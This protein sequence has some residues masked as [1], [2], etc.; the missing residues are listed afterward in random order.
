MS[1]RLVN[2]FEVPASTP[3]NAP[4]ATGGDVKSLISWFVMRLVKGFP[5]ATHVNHRL[6]MKVPPDRG[7]A[8]P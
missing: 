2:P 4:A 6:F 7:R 3:W 8:V 1:I 5:G